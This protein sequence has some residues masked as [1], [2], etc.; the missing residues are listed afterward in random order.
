MERVSAKRDPASYLG[1]ALAAVAWGSVGV[2]V[3]W[4]GLAGHEFQLVL[5]RSALATAFFGGVALATGKTSRL[6]LGGKPVL[7]LGSGL[8]LT[9][10]WLVFFKAIDYL[11]L[12]QAVFITYL[13]PVL[14][15]ALAPLVL[16]E[17][18]EGAT[19]GALTLSLTGLF[20]MTTAARGQGGLRTG[21]V[22]FALLAAVTYALLL[23]ILKKL[24]EEVPALTVAFYQSLVNVVVLLPFTGFRAFPLER[25]GWLSILALGLLH[26]GAVGLLY[27][28]AVK[29]VKAQ[30]VGV[31]SYL[32]PMSAYLFGWLALGERLG[33]GDF[34]GG[35]LIL[36][37]GLVVVL[38]RPQEI[39][40]PSPKA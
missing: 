14:V 13:A 27:I 30:H 5:L 4:S 28:N 40:G 35:A 16:R 23:L 25:A 29:R 17:R 38:H 18:L 39:L 20:L 31:I 8:L 10:H 15:A 19:L 33:W 1:V 24:R 22:V 34:L 11:A 3:R 2:M 21:G 32:E 9:I 36:A 6:R 37:G 12:G 26:S 7:L